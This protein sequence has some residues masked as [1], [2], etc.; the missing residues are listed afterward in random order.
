MK[1]L[2][3][4]RTPEEY[5]NN[6]YYLFHFLNPFLDQA[7][8]Y[9]KD[10]KKIETHHEWI[11]TYEY[12]NEDRL[13]F[14]E[15]E[16]ICNNYNDFYHAYIIGHKVTLQ[17]SIKYLYNH[18]KELIE[19]INFSKQFSHNKSREWFDS[20]ITNAEDLVEHNFSKNDINIDK[21]LI[22][23]YQKMKEFLDID[24]MQ[25]T[26]EIK[27]LDTDSIIDILD[28]HLEIF[29]YTSGAFNRFYK[30]KGKLPFFVKNNINKGLYPLSW[31]SH[32]NIIFSLKR[33]KKNYLNKQNKNFDEPIKFKHL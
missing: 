26:N 8:E 33:I 17:N 24:I 4:T 25:T 13:S 14:N 21:Y 18:K 12:N 19:F 30:T 10:L 9:A 23:S 22:E 32:E 7:I 20:S 27:T 2:D 29:L 16:H 28:K 6:L 1:F 3:K 11:K 15:F 31:V 5:Y